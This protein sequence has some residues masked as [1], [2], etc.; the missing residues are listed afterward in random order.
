MA[1][2]TEQENQDKDTLK[3][4]VHNQDVY[5]LFIYISFYLS[6][7]HI[8]RIYYI[9]TELNKHGKWRIIWFKYLQQLKEE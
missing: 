8:H 2:Q 1:H 4:A 7:G 6:L 9:S 3:A 5:V